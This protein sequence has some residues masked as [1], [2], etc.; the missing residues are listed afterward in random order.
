[1][2]EQGEQSRLR[3]FL[4]PVPFLAGVVVA[5]V[6][7]CLG[8]HARS[9]R[10]CYRDFARFTGH[11][12]PT[13]SYFP[14]ACQLRALGRA[15]LDPDKVVV[16][17]GGNSILQGAGQARSE[18]WSNH[19]QTA[20]GDRFA[21]LN[22]ASVGA[23]AA[24]FGEIAAEF[25]ARDHPRLVYI[26]DIGSAGTG[27]EP[28]GAIYRYFFWDAY[29]KGLVPFDRHREERLAELTAQRHK[30]G[31]E[32]FAEL[33]RGQYLDA[34]VRFQDLWTWVT[35]QHVSTVWTPASPHYFLRARKVFPDPL[36]AP[37]PSLEQ[38]YPVA[39]EGI[40][41]KIVGAW[42]AG[43]LGMVQGGD[44]N[45]ALA[46]YVHDCFPEAVRPRTL[47]LVIRDSPHYVSR[48]HSAEQARYAATFPATVRVLEA[49][50]L[51]ALDVGGDYS[52]L[53]YVD[54]CHLSEQGGRRLAAEVAPKVRDLA[55]RL[56]Y[57]KQGGPR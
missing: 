42:G 41:M 44:R 6:A 36:T 13:T 28:D 11:T 53:D 49:N 10:N 43:G 30:R 5:F 37:Q 56:G 19:L 52:D 16:V 23:L 33:Q 24:E 2:S 35:Y 38:R 57:L 40:A 4:V 55:R 31:D 25:L 46:R 7:C 45:C 29:Y 18:M 54:R 39:V 34:G 50:G 1:M 51:S 20:L 12:D 8:G 47:I 3:R 17:V 32:A 21:V 15:R 14:T 9:G 48:L 27:G 26:A 22:F